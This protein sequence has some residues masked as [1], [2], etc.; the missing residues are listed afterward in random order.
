VDD[1]RPKIYRFGPFEIDLEQRVLFRAGDSVPLTPK[2]FDTLAVLVARPGRV[3]DK[4]ELLKLVWPDTFVEEN[5]LTQNISALRKVFGASDYIET[6][7]RRGYRFSIGV[8]DVSDPVPAPADP[9]PTPR[10]ATGHRSRLLWIWGVLAVAALAAL[11]FYAAGRIRDARPPD[12]QVDSLVVLPFV[13]LSAKA[14]DEYFSDGLTEELTNAVAHLDGLRVVARTTAFQFKGKAR[15]IR[16]IAQQLHVGAVL[17]GSVRRQ[18]KRLRVTVQLNDARTG[19]HLWSQ[20]YDRGEADI[21]NVQQDISNQVARSIR[22]DKHSVKAPK[23]STDLEAYNSY[24]LGLFYQRQPYLAPKRRAMAFFEQAILKDP[25]YAAA[26]AG[27]AQCYTQLAWNSSM[28]PL[29]A[30]TSA[31]RAA[32]EAL[33]LDDN[34]AEAHTSQ[35]IVHLQLDWNWNAAEREFRRAIALNGND[36]AAHHWFSHY[37]IAMNRFSESLTESRRALEL[38]PLDVQI[39]GHMIW[40]YLRTR[41]Y[42]NAI[43]AGLQTLELDPHSELAFLFLAWTYEDTGQWDKAIEAWQFANMI[44]PEGSAL[45]AALDADGPRGYWRARLAFLSKQKNVSNYFLAVLHARLGESDEALKRL[46]LALHLREPDL[47]YLKREPA[48]DW[49]QSSPRFKTLTDAMNLP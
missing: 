12:H 46:E 39:S 23:T 13:N 40:H 7:P 43:K 34:L 25:K 8:E 27:L 26:Y 2:A 49:M 5:N 30:W 38:D 20:T 9:Q 4:G 36:A 6:I 42:S 37:F 10:A 16:S 11:T 45:R 33:R 48:F 19:Y 1:V 18:D 47:I 24:L 44:H 32:T 28:P 22:P 21:F 3:V 35:A 29:E 31:Q 17:E 14:E 41:E 15:D